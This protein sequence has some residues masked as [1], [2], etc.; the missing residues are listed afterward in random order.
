MTETRKVGSKKKKKKRK[1][2]TKYNSKKMRK[3][4]ELILTYLPYVCLI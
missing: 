3:L 1:R 4:H 2:S